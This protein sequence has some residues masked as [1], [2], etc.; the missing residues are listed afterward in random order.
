MKTLKTEDLE[1]M[2]RIPRL[3]LI[4]SLAGYKSANLIGTKSAGGISNL[5]IFSSV[6]HLGSNPG[7]LGLIMRPPVVPRHTYDNIRSQKVY[8]INHIHSGQIEAAHQTSGKY[9]EGISE[10]DA[11]GFEEEFI[12]EFAAPFVSDSRVKLGMSLVEEIPIKS[13]GCILIV[14]EIKIVR[15]PEETLKPNGSLDLVHA[16]TVAI[17]GLDSY[18]L[19]KHLQDMPY[20][21][22]RSLRG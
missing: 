20:V 7:L 12:A 19:P 9:E 5:A 4:N 3:N 21:S 17:S 15:L 16:D 2:D 18:H 10:F 8:T 22:S 13:N 1:S 11:C 6:I 14:G